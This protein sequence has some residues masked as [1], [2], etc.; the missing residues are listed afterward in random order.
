MGARRTALRHVG[1]P[2]TLW[3]DREVAE[4]LA[5]C[6]DVEPGSRLPWTHGLHP[7]PAR[8]H[9]ETARRAI[10]AFRPPGGAVF[11]PFVGSGTTAVEALRAG[12]PFTGSDLSPVAIEIAWTRTRFLS[13]ADCRKLELESARI[14]RLAWRQFQE[15]FRFPPWA[16]PERKWY[17]PH[18]LK[19]ICLLKS[20]IDEVPDPNRRIL[21]V[22]L[23]SLVVKLSWQI[24]DSE[25]GLAPRRVPWPPG[26][27]FRFFR[28]RT[29]EFSRALRNLGADLRRRGIRPAEPLFFLA[30]ARAARAQVPAALALTSP[31]YPGTYDYALH[32]ERRYPI[33]GFRPEPLRRG[34][35]GARRSWGP[36]ATARYEEDL[37][38]CL[39]SL[40]RSLAPGG[41]ILM[42]IGDGGTE[43]NPYRTDR[44]LLGIA[45][46]AGA[47]VVALASQP[48]ADWT[49]GRPRW[50]KREHL[51]AMETRSGSEQGDG[52]REE[53]EAEQHDRRAVADHVARLQPRNP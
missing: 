43:R 9:P 28:A 36:E 29:A 42:Q 46:R 44:M 19:E 2:C 11:D 25:T 6:L 15:D 38:R 31:P 27:A 51:V 45:E 18:T 52:G 32:H 34:E 16:L 4:Q 23:S 22:A 26:T 30:D 35:I 1:G 7:Y 49:G 39:Q 50:W 21:R 14:V 3:G 10:E 8:M 20:L 40:V 41:R 12:A 24:S 17:A 48:R 33:F 5:R 47:R 37:R 53:R 13:P